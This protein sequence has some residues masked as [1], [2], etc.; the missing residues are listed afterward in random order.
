PRGKRKTLR[1][2]KVTAKSAAEVCRR[3]E[4]LLAAR[5]AGTSLERETAAWLASL[6]GVLRKRLTAVGLADKPADVDGGTRLAEFL[7]AYLAGRKDLK[8]STLEQLH[9]S[10]RCLIG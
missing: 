4:L 6:D 7:N 2:G 3:V 8:A 10:R 9:Q 1:L 5:I